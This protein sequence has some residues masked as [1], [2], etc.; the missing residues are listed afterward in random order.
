MSVRPSGHFTNV[1][2]P[3]Q[4]LG[5]RCFYYRV[6]KLV[7][8]KEGKGGNELRAGLWC[9]I[10]WLCPKGKKMSRK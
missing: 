9:C 6:E 7:E 1:W 5:D 4:F 3:Q 8:V 10:P 2:C